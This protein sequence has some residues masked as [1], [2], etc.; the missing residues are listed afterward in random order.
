MPKLAVFFPGIGY[1]VDKPLM[2]YCRNLVKKHGY[3]IKLIPYKGFP[4]KVK[5]DQDKMVQSYEIA[6]SQSVE[7]LAEVN[8]ESYEEILFIGKSVG[9]IVAASLACASEVK[10]RIRMILYTPLTETFQFDFSDAIVFTGSADPWV[11]G[12]DSKISLLCQ[13][14]NIP[15][16]LIENGNHSLETQNVFEDLENIKTIMRETEKFLL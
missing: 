6:L 14:R 2:H 16:F 13:Q 10:E 3:D 9:T 15:C 11:G 12:K 7:M 5:G 4:D 1:T 8:F